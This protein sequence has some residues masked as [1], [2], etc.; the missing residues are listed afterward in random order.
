ME[1]MSVENM[2]Q[3]C[4][5]A[6]AWEELGPVDI[7]F[8][9]TVKRIVM[10]EIPAQEQDDIFDEEGYFGEDAPETAYYQEN[11][12]ETVTIAPEE[13]EAVEEPAVN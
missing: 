5:E 13:A 4:N 6:L 2:I 12:E 7:L 8:F 1:R 3:Y 9:D 10:G 11:A